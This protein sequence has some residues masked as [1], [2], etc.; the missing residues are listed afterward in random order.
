VVVEEVIVEG[1]MPVDMVVDI[2]V[3]DTWAEVEVEEEVMAI[4]LVVKSTLEMF[5][6]QS[7]SNTQF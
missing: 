1:L 3:E 6:P 2:P 4:Q 7:P 5:S